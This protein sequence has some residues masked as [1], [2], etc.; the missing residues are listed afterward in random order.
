MSL[1]R[2]SLIVLILIFGYEV[3][4]GYRDILKT[5]SNMKDGVFMEIVN[6]FQLFSIPTNDPLQ[7]LDRF[8]YASELG[9]NVYRVS[10]EFIKLY[11]IL[12]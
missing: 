9:I 10:I 8:Q 1:A 2:F 4:T 7:M 5:L 11:T 3:M 6:D 12:S